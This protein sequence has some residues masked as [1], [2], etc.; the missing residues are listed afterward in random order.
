MIIQITGKVKFPITLDASVWI[1]DDRKILLE[2]AFSI[3]SRKKVQKENNTVKEAAE[4]LSK[5][6]TT[7]PRVRHINPNM[8]KQEREDALKYSYV[9]PIKQFIENSEPEQSAK[10][11]K[12]MT[13]QG[14]FEITLSQLK[15]S[16]LHFSNKGKPIDDNGPVHLYF[17][18]GSNKNSPI[19]GITKIIID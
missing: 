19:K 18:D 14:E 11:A 1:F 16:V 9:M 10:L 12:L 4:R 2:E 3:Q 6:Y 13:N 7:D 5:A 17:Q 8:D 15:N